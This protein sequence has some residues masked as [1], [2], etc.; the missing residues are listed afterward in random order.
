MP[1]PELWPL[2]QLAWKL[3]AEG[4]SYGE[5]QQ[6]THGQLY[7]SKNSWSSFFAN[8]TYL[9]IGKCGSLEIPDHHPAAIDQETW[10]AVQAIEQAHPRQAQRGHVQHPRR[11]ASPSLLSGFATCAACGSAMLYTQAQSEAGKAW[12]HYLCGKKQRQGASA[13]PSKRVNARLADSAVL[14]AVLN[15]ILTADF[16]EALLAQVQAQ[17]G[18]TAA[19]EQEIDQTRRAMQSTQRAI[20]NLL[21]AIEQYG[22]AAAGERLKLRQVEQASLQASLA[23]LEQ[24]KSADDLHLTPE[25][26]ALVVARWRQQF[27]EAAR[28]GEIQALRDLLFPA[29]ISQVELSATTLRIH[30]TFPLEQAQSL[31]H[32]GRLV[33]G[34]MVLEMPKGERRVGRP[35]A[36]KTEPTTR[37]VE[38][39][40]RHVAGETV[41]ALAE[42]YGL[43]EQR[44][45]GICTEV[46]RW[47]RK[48]QC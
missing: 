35:V 30:Y 15:R 21:D 27:D 17:V 48:G 18:D 4:K 41:R 19:L 29:L 14:D 12:P 38:I 47:R 7:R 26:L 25:A 46:R 44:V 16:F 28:S 42:A 9:G 32:A 24:Q 22:P 33:V 8:K 37:D 3:R 2:V 5:I 13:C 11:R 43:S 40:D 45:W 1:D 10:N 6:A 36:K 20:A 34:S 31:Y 39:Y 23:H